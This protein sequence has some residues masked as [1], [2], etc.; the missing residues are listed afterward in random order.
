MAFVFSS[1]INKA[2]T[3]SIVGY[4]VAMWTNGTLGAMNVVLWHDPGQWPLAL[5]VYPLANFGRLIYNLT[6]VCSE[7]KCYTTW[8]AMDPE[9]LSLIKL[10]FLYGFI[11]L[12]A[13]MYLHEVVK[14]EHGVSQN[15]LFCLKCLRKKKRTEVGL[16]D[17]GR[18][19][20]FIRGK[21]ED[22]DA[23]RERD[24]VYNLK[25]FTEHTLVIKDLRKE[26]P[27]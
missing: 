27:P 25:D 17:R 5:A 1:M 10:Q 8:G 2:K 23:L 19:T 9:T 4:I 15:W 7:H 22:E 6:L 13:G 3:A 20:S 24:K 12:S 11:W 26:F 18:E 16:E 14:T 21:L